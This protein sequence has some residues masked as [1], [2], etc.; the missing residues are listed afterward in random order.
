MKQNAIM[1]TTGRRRLLGLA[2]LLAL[3]TLGGCG[4]SVV[5]EDVGQISVATGVVM[6]EADLVLTEADAGRVI[7]APTFSADIGLPDKKGVILTLEGD[8]ASSLRWRFAEKPDPFVV[9]WYGVDDRLAFETG[10]LI[11]DPTTAKRVLEFRP[12]AVG[13]A[14]FVLELVERDPGGP[15]RRAG[16]ASG[17]HVL[18]VLRAGDR[19]IWGGLPGTDAV[20]QHRLRQRHL[21]VGPGNAAGRE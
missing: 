13:E 5:G 15:R 1:R 21:W 8:D 9:E 20:P 19:R 16:Q 17:V 10:D 4:E 2:A 7:E 6:T 3:A 18:G 11:G 14:V 12:S